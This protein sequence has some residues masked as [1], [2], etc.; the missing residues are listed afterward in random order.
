MDQCYFHNRTT[1]VVYH[2]HDDFYVRNYHTCVDYDDYDLAGYEYDAR[3]DHD[4]GDVL[5]HLV[6][7]D[8][9]QRAIDHYL[10]HG[11]G[12]HHYDDP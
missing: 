10:D 4:G 11:P 1:G 8:L 7:N 2:L 5:N 6:L 3:R 12:D 9:V